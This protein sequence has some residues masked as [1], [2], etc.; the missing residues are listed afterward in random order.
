MC[1]LVTSDVFDFSS[2]KVSYSEEDRAALQAVAEDVLEAWLDD[3][4]GNK[5]KL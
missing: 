2:V 4:Y 3:M 5:A 1:S